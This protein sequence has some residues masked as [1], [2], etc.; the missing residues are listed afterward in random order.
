MYAEMLRDDMVPGE[1]RKHD[2]YEI[3]TAESERLSRLIQNVLELARLERGNRPMNLEVGNPGPLLREVVRTLAPH[4]TDRGFELVVQAPDDLPAVRFDRDG[5]TQVL[6]N[7]VDNAIKFSAEAADK[8]V[9]IEARP[10]AGG[11]AL[12]VV[13]FGPGVPQRHLRNLFQPFYRGERELVRRTQGTGIGLALVS[14][15]VRGMGGAVRAWNPTAGGFAVELSLV[16][17]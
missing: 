1:E 8:R 16:G 14:G 11:I 9:I 17:A 7:L 5:L 15:L 12:R 6:I 13:D 10:S 4:A 3:I 2:Y